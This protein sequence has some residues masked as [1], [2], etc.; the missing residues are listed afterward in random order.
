MIGLMRLKR[1]SLL[2][3]AILGIFLPLLSV[4]AQQ[5]APGKWGGTASIGVM[6]WSNLD[7][8]QPPGGGGFDS[9]GFAMEIAGHR[10][11][12]RW[13]SADVL[14]GVDVGLFATE[15]DFA[16]ISD[17][18]TQRGLYLTPS[19]KFRFG[20]REK[21]HLNLEAG[22]GWYKVDFAE[23]DC[24]SFP[25]TEIADPFDKDTFGGYVGVSGGFGGWFVLGLKV[26]FAD[27][28]EVTGLGPGV[29]SLEGPFYI[30]SAGAAFGN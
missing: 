24:S 30:F 9:V 14:A 8:L 19:V 25:C 12:T 27:F 20:E 6:F 26:H 17:D 1:Q 28:G 23:L 7:D 15:S 4:S 2:A 16:G 3:G 11:M 22:A 10:H 29:G 21:R 18:F 13:G 5:D